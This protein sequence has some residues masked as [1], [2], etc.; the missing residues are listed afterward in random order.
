MGASPMMG[1]GGMGGMGGLGM[2]GMSPQ[3]AVGAAHQPAPPTA[4]HIGG[5]PF[6]RVLAET[7]VQPESTEVVIYLEPTTGALRNMTLQLDP[8]AAL[9]IGVSAAPPA[10][11]AGTRVTIPML[12]PGGAARLAISVTCAAA[13]G[14]ETPLLG[15]LV[16]SDAASVTDTRVVSFRLVLGLR[17]LL[18]PNVIQTQDFGGMWPA[19]SQERKSMIA[20]CAVAADANAYN[21]LIQSKLHIYPVQTIGMECIA[22]TKLVGTVPQQGL[23]CLVHAKLGQM[24]GRA[25]ELTLRSKDPRLTDALQKEVTAVLQG[26]V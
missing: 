7:S 25:L 20:P 10:A 12:S 8:G 9:K 23:T 22:C 11:A 18:R 13:V 19:H 26:G 17:Q 21:G 3:A 16:Y 6:I 2:G 4:S 15:Q 24:N 14:A 1:G 5:D